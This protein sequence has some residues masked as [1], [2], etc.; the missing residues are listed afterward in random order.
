[1]A[2]LSIINGHACADVQGGGWELTTPGV[3]LGVEVL[4]MDF[5]TR[6]GSFEFSKFEF[7]AKIDPKRRTKLESGKDCKSL[8][9][10]HTKYLSNKF[11]LKYLNWIFLIGLYID[12]NN[13]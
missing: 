10:L 1:M 13:Q 5:H 7:A 9:Y 6:I 12:R 3:G 2:P 8:W 11:T 4:S